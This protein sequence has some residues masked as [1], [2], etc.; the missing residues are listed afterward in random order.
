MN[1]PEAVMLF[2]AG[3]G[4]RMGPLTADRPKPMV[5]VA[6]RPLIDHALDHVDAYDPARRV[7]NVHYKPETLIAH[8]KNRGVTISD[9]RGALLETGGG[10]R[11]ALPLLGDGPVFTMNTDAVFS[12]PNPLDFL[13]QAWDPRAMDALLLCLPS[14]RAHGHTGSGDFIVGPDGRLSRGPGK[15]YTGVQILK[16]DGLAR[17]SDTAFSLNLLW[18]DM[19]SDGR[20]FGA[21]Y[22]SEWCDVGT[23]AGVA[24]AE[25]MLGD[26]DV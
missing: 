26:H 6:G 9:E 22:P 11:A 1:R 15:I 23:P 2:A 17:I 24:A 16:T 8:L 21:C 3:L 7:A 4:S 14:E 12:G 18:D 10:L 19:L 5:P 25:A 13:A 20:L